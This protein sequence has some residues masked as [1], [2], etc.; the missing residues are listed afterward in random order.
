MNFAMIF[1]NKLLRNTLL[2]AGLGLLS[3]CN[4]APKYTRPTIATPAVFKE[5]GGDTNLWRVAQPND[6]AARGK[7][8]VMFN[9]AQLNALEDQVAV[10]NQNVAAAF[11]NFL[12]ARALVRE[13]RSQYFPTLLAD[14]SVTR[15]RTPL[16]GQ[17]GYQGYHVTDYTLP[18]DA[19]WQPDLW[20]R[21]QNTVRGDKAAAQASAADLENTRL[22]AQGELAVDY[23]QLRAQDAL[24]QLYDNTVADYRQ[25]YEL[26]KVLFKTGIDSDQDVAQAETQLETAQATATNLGILRAQLE[27]AIAMLTGR[28]ASAFS[29][30]PQPLAATSVTVPVVLPSQLLERRP[31][32]AATERSVAQANAQIGTTKAAYYPTI[33]LSASGGFEST[34]FG[35]LFDWPNR[36]WSI[37]A[38]ASETL[39]DF[40]ARSASVAQARAAYDL[41][42]AQYRQT[43]LAAFQQVEDDLATLRILGKEIPQ[44]ETAV[45]SSARYLDLAQHR[46]RLGIDSYLNVITAQTTLLANRQTLVNLRSQ[47]M[48]ATVQLIEAL[49]GGWDAGQLNAA[50]NK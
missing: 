24:Q 16:L 7:W 29:L 33:T 5:Q 40:G 13:A 12:S 14:P 43:V 32:I 44:Q 50:E 28:S 47:Q 20:G 2:L 45:Q 23:F 9:D 22:T 48:T 1:R 37:G 39:L 30:S 38:G 36:F 25:S 41:A 34:A 31:D 27:H 11:A 49:G 18:L 19:S 3:G 10:S 21:V 26:T 35:S 4:L 17:A 46:Y 8:W 42:V 6:A 15:S